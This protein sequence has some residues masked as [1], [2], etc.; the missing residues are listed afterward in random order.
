MI[1]WT[2]I[3][4]PEEKEEEKLNWT[5][6]KPPISDEERKRRLLETIKL[7]GGEERLKQH[8]ATQE[9][10]G[11]RETGFKLEKAPEEEE[12]FFTK[13][14]KIFEAKPIA[15]I[16]KAQVSYNISQ[17]TGV[18]VE[19]VH[20]N[21]DKY[22]KDLGIRG[23][24]T[25]EEFLTAM[26]AF[27]VTAGL[28]AHPITTGIGVTKFLALSEAENFAISKLKKWEYRFGAGVGIKELLPEETSQLTKDVVDV[29]DFIGKG[30]IIAKTDPKLMKIWKSF[31][32]KISTEYTMP[33]NVYVSAEK[34]K[35]IFGTLPPHKLSAEELQL[36]TDLGLNA[37]QYKSAI[38]KGIDIEIPA[39]RITTLTDRPY[40]AKIKGLFNAKPVT[41]T[42]VTR[43]GKVAPAKL[44]IEGKP[45]FKL[46]YRGYP[47]EMPKDVLKMPEVKP[48]I[49]KEM[50]KPEI[51]LG[52]KP[53]IG[54][55]YKGKAFRSETRIPEHGA[56]IIAKMKTAQEKLN[57][58]Y[59]TT[60]NFAFKKAGELAKSLGIDLDKV[61]VGEMVWV[62]PTF[63]I[64]EKY[65]GAKE[66]KLP[67]DTI[68]LA[69]DNEGGFLVLKN[70]E[71]YKSREIGLTKEEIYAEKYGIPLEKVKIT[72]IPK[73]VPT[74][75]EAISKLIE[76]G[77]RLEGIPEPTKEDLEFIE[78]GFTTL[79]KEEFVAKV[80]AKIEPEEVVSPEEMKSMLEYEKDMIYQLSTGREKMRVPIGT[81]TEWKEAL[82]KGKYMQIFRDDRTLPTTDE[83]ASSLGISENELREQIIERI[84]YKPEKLVTPEGLVVGE[85]GVAYIPSMKEVQNIGTKLASIVSIE[86]PFIKAGAKETGFQVKN[87]Y[88]NIGLAH[89]QGLKLIN[90]FNKFDVRP[91][92]VTE[93]GFK[94]SGELDYTDITYLSERPG[95]FVKLTP[96]ERKVASPAKKA[97]KDFAEMWFK[98]IN[99]IGWLEEPFP[100]SLITRNNRKI[101]NMKASL[102]RLKTVEARV[103][104][105]AE[106]KK[107]QDQIDRI[108]KQKIQFVSI[109]AKAILAKADTDPALHAKI[110]SILPH[111]G[112]TTITV[113]DL[114]DANI[115]SRK[116]ADIRNII[117]EYSDRM[118]RKYALGKIFEN[119][120]KE[121]LIKSSA[122]KPD[123]PTVRIFIKGQ[124][125]SIPQLR[126]KRLDPFFSDVITDFFSREQ[127]GMG[128]VFGIIKMMQFHNPL[129]MPMYDVQ[130]SAAAGMIRTIK[131]PI[132]I[133]QGIKDSFKKTDNYWLAYENG[134][135]SKPFVIPYDKWE[136]QFTEAMKD[137]KM[138]EFL[139]KAALPTNWIPMLYTASWH[140]AWKLD[141]TVRMMTF[142]MFQDQGMN[143]RDA[144]QLAALYHSDYASVPPRTRKAL[145]KV[146]FT[147]TFKIT[148]GKLY[149][150]MLEGSIKTVTK[151]KNATQRE[152]NLA[153][154]A[155]T[156][157]AILMGRKLYMQSKGFT[158]T[159]LFRKY[160]KDTE[161]DEGMKEDVVTFSDP[162]NIPFRY[163]GRVK[164]AFK[165]QTTNVAEKMLQIVK[166]DLHPIH[167]VTIDVVDNYNWNV[168]NPFDDSKTIAK[169]IAIYTTGEFVRIT[170]GL[171]ESAK[172]GEI[173]ADAFKALQKDL[174]KFE[175]IIL[176][177]FVF[178]YLREPMAKRKQWAINKLRNDF[179]R[180]MLV[181]PSKDPKVN[182]ERLQNF[183][184]RLQEIMKDFQ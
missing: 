79:S 168:Y 138:G 3:K 137:N 86:A 154:G 99:E 19:E 144:A 18:P 44:M 12:T 2:L 26:F 47:K 74:E 81:K 67:E 121:G 37:S 49:P 136:Y 170:K 64:A 51:E 101:G 108:K 78:K 182:Y 6:I 160:V 23:I 112:R 107:L 82:G 21:L 22:S 16:A 115:I 142:N 41:E 10:L 162:F 61:P 69:K 165:P 181:S 76:E 77:E 122:E 174:G 52:I 173:K 95:Y 113:K 150:N 31:T 146:F 106:I 153:K 105:L 39:S 57:Y 88:S 184:K 127:V 147:P 164:G 91:V 54:K 183:N 98:K 48:V 176:K 120:E 27:P 4:E 30:L 56:E 25:S 8:L 55:P 128:G 141:E 125:V 38:K 159:E 20:K 1:D 161:T 156:A 134:L 11:K 157:L 83:M 169:D 46:S 177:P 97:Y 68:I 5:T 155:L 116:E 143:D 123:W 139:K 114:V 110:M 50:P 60:G 42:V 89:G 130:Q 71:K 65:D 145:N 152:K 45:K 166:W 36:I 33:K 179:S 84:R 43:G 58:D 131:A 70:S 133:A 63:K 72:E 35:S 102:P 34:V 103:K 151:G 96:E 7:F 180:M 62:A 148:M 94:A 132:Y 13:F 124:H 53:E 172:E 40:W 140:T 80:K 129:F 149:L 126:G 92:T 85:A 117:G 24:P 175:A 100:K 75:A 66:L 163:L 14:K 167:R 171:L 109:P 28:I 15:Q 93:S 135:F 9:L 29:A 73:V 17:K 111:W 87:Y 158:E 59:S 118:G 90:D 104:V 32:Q 178:N 119:A